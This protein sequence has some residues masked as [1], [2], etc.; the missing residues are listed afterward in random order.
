M[1]IRP[2]GGWHPEKRPRAV[3]GLA[4]GR[5]AQKPQKLSRSGQASYERQI[6]QAIN[7]SMEPAV[8]PARARK[9]APTT[10]AKAAGDKRKAAETQVRCRMHHAL[11]W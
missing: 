11:P 9:L 5:V 1:I 8:T 4:E 10:S 2:R 6:A 7:A 3:A